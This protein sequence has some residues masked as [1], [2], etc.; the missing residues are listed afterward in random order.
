M[1]LTRKFQS[2]FMCFWEYH[3][4]DVTNWPTHE[5]NNQPWGIEIENTSE[6]WSYSMV[7]DLSV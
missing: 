1:L 6:P 2:L 5:N 4:L 3:Q 7:V